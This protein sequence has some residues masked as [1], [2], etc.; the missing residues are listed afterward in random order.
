MVSSHALVCILVAVVPFALADTTKTLQ[1]CTTKLGGV[2]KSSVGSTTYGYTFTQTATQKITVTPTST[3]TPTITSVFQEIVTS[4]STAKETV[5][6]SP[7]PVIIPTSSGFIPING[8]PASTA[9]VPA[10]RDPASMRIEE[11]EELVKRAAAVAKCSKVTRGP[12]GPVRS[13]ALYPSTVSCAQLVKVVKTKTLTSTAA[14]ITI[15]APAPTATTTITVYETATSTITVTAP[16][17]TSYAAC[18]AK[19]MLPGYD[20]IIYTPPIAVGNIIDVD[21]VAS[22][23]ECCVLCETTANCAAG[24][25]DSGFGVQCELYIYSTCQPGSSIANVT[26]SNAF[27]DVTLFNG[28]C[29]IFTVTRK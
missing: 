1:M 27:T 23:Y 13:P 12:N 16:A 2:S 11:G 17:Q 7:A 14:P 8:A 10:K 18:A 5:T 15:T 21:N 20:S 24:Y 19:N 26:V 29:G 6:S 3:I 28:A 9:A 25:F 4:T 22:A